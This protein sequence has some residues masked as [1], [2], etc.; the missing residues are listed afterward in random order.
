MNWRS[1]ISDIQ[2]SI[3]AVSSDS[4][5][6]PRYIYSEAQNITAFFLKTDNDAKKKLSSISEG[7]SELECIKLEEVEVINCP[8][9]DVRL[10]DKMMKSVHPIPD[11]YTY[12]YGNIIEYTASPN[13]SYFFDPTT[14]RKW[15][16]IQK[17]KYKDKNKY[18]YFIIDHYLYLPIPKEVDLPI[19]S[20]RMKAY[21]MDKKSTEKFKGFGDCGTCPKEELCKSTLDYEMVIPSYLV[22]AVKDELIRKLSQVY[23]KVPGDNYP[24]LNT[25]DLNNNKD[26]QTYGS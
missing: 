24:N 7:W 3:K 17:Q 25:N 13:W 9:I 26:L 18:Y 16:N 5:I 6:P 11:I 21:F 15:R 4:Y 19:E 22:S 20:L 23:L 10:C 12:S 8:D 1:F 14:P 2:S